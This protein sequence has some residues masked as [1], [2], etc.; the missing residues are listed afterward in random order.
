MV[1]CICTLNDFCSREKL[2][3]VHVTLVALPVYGNLIFD[4]CISFHCLNS[5]P[6]LK[7]NTDRQMN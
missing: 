1:E 4:F 5:Q 6:S 3:T 2:V 7:C